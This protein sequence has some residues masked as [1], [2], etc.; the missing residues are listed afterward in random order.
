MAMRI[1]Q[2]KAAD[3]NKATYLPSNQNDEIMHMH[4]TD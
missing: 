3:E 2:E 4:D 1:F